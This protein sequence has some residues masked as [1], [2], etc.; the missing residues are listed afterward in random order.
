MAYAKYSCTSDSVWFTRHLLEPPFLSC[1]TLRV[2]HM[3]KRRYTSGHMYN[4]KWQWELRAISYSSALQLTCRKQLRKFPVGSWIISWPVSDSKAL[5]I[6][7]SWF[8]AWDW[9]KQ[10]QLLTP[11]LFHEGTSPP[12]VQKQPAGIAA[13]KLWLEL[14]QS[15]SYSYIQQ[16]ISVRF[17]CISRKSCTVTCRGA[18]YVL[19]R[20]PQVFCNSVIS[21]C[22]MQGIY[23]LPCIE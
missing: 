4:M 3:G 13:E 23:F 8:F 1:W 2:L 5:W 15:L 11:V 10:N 12:P 20:A 9:A 18:L 22:C 6:D 7:L 16:L 14:P 21:C 17:R 19:P